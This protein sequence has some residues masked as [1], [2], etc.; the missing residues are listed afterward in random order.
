[1]TKKSFQK[2]D[3][4]KMLVSENYSKAGVIL[5]IVFDTRRK[6]TNGLYNVKFRV[7]H[8][9]K[10]V[11]YNAGVDLS[12][13]EWY[14]MTTTRKK[15]LLEQK[16]LIQLGFD[17]IKSHII[18]LIKNGNF[19][20]D[21]L[22]ARLS[23]GMQNSILT[24]FYNKIEKLNKNGQ[25]GTA[26]WYL[27]TVK[28]IEKFIIKDLKFSD[29]NKTWLQKYENFLI[30]EDKS[31]TTISMYMRA[32]RAIM[33]DAKE[34]DVITNAEYPFGK[35]KD[36]FKIQNWTGRKMALSLS[37]IDEV[38]K[39]PLV[40]ETERKCRDLWLFM[41]LCNG[42]SV[43]DLLRLRYSNIK[44]SEVRFYRKKTTRTN[45]DQ[46]EIAATL[47]PQMQTIIEKWGNS[48]RK[49][50]NYIFPFLYGDIT[51][52]DE[53]RIVK[54]LTKLINDKLTKIGQD[55]GYGNISTYTAR[56]SF[57]TVLK[58]SG[59][60]IAFISESLG[61]SNQK[62]TES[63]LDSFEKEERQKNAELLLR[64][65]GDGKIKK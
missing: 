19:S 23:R 62:T 12:L 65:E 56:H 9:R 49:P 14:A 35:G 58:R 2:N 61:H 39:Y 5:S 47:L 10:Q 32:I 7:T 48:D 52:I 46:K 22:N 28:N 17:G 16:G 31:R 26:G 60:N 44:D 27:C 38:L 24:A 11:Y 40:T 13:N 59:T 64:F 6:K 53:K 45:P 4:P 34:E 55:L 15:D 42:I 3:E 36:K 29:I 63:Y 21:K 1:M 54:N 25:V 33:N 18:A 41:Y 43:N 50:T 37:Q 30:E 51:P 8:K 20:Y 57:A